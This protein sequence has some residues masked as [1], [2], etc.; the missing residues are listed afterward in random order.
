VNRNRSAA[1]VA[2]GSSADLTVPEVDFRFT[3]ESGL[4][5]DIG[6]CLFRAISGD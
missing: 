4:A 2:Y 6:P 3:P 5:S 1:E